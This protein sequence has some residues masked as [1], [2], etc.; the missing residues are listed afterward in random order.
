M[1]SVN[2]QIK[3]KIM[4]KTVIVPL[5]AF[6]MTSCASV[7]EKKISSQYQVVSDNELYDPSIDEAR[8]KAEQMKNAKSN[9]QLDR[10]RNAS[11]E[12]VGVS[13]K[14][15]HVKSGDT[16]LVMGDTDLALFQYISALILDKND[17]DLYVKIGVIHQQL[18]N[19]DLAELAYRRALE[20]D[21]AFVPALERLGRLELN[22]RQYENAGKK[23]RRALEEDARRLAALASDNQKQADENQEVATDNLKQAD[24]NQD[25]AT[26]NLKQADENQDVASDSQE[27]AGENQEVAAYDKH[28]PYLAYTGL[29]V[30]ADLNKN[31]TAAIKYF[32]TAAAIRPKSASAANN[33]GYSYYLAENLEQAEVHFRN[34]LMLD[35]DFDRALRNLALLYVRRDRLDDALHLL[36]NRSGNEPESYNTLGYLCMMDGKYEVADDYFNKAIELSPTYFEVA[37][38]NREKNRQRYSHTIYRTLN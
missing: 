3:N 28:S 8:I 33:I 35:P 9:T 37:V 4:S 10:E 19:T 7:D 15:E 14:A 31:H 13:K 38:Q 27:Q 25:V 21:A 11:V 24:E 20:A 32:E 30:I 22:Q 17:P 36:L 34:A 6:L 16:A 29:G 12:D 1:H 18:G 5:L 23:F 2:N 26:D